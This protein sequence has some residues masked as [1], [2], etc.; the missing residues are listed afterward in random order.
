MIKKRI[1]VITLGALAILSGGFTSVLVRHR[2]D[3]PKTSDTDSVSTRWHSVR[4]PYD[5]VNH[6]AEEAV[7]QVEFIVKPGLVFTVDRN[8]L[9]CDWHAQESPTRKPVESFIINCHHVSFS[10]A[11]L[12]QLDD[13]VLIR[14]PNNFGSTPHLTVRI[15]ITRGPL[16]PGRIVALDG[17]QVTIR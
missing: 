6:G 7:E 5:P 2:Y 14:V 1:I 3:D 12:H 9:P 17:T 8:K 4:F 15:W 16:G 13:V 11:N 10:V